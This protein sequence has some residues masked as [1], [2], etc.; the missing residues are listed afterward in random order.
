MIGCGIGLGTSCVLFHWAFVCQFGWHID[1]MHCAPIRII[2]GVE[3]ILVQFMT[4]IWTWLSKVAFP[5]LSLIEGWSTREQE[6]TGVIIE[7]F[8]TC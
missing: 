7:Q 1:G 2:A 8:V 4:R 5:D 3:A 6:S